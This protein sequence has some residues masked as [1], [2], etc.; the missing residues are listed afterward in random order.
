MI[1]K[2]LMCGAIFAKGEDHFLIGYGKRIWS[3]HAVNSSSPSWYF[4][5]FFLESQMPWFT[6]E[7][8]S[9]ISRIELISLLGSKFMEL[10]PLIWEKLCEDVFERSFCDLQQKFAEKTL[11]KVVPYLV[12]RSSCRNSN[13]RLL[14]ML[15]A[16]LKHVEKGRMAIYGFWDM[17]EGILGATPELLFEQDGEVSV[18][19]MACA[20][21]L[22]ANAKPTQILE[23]KLLKEHQIVVDDMVSSLTVL[24]KVS[25]GKT[26]WQSFRTL[27]HLITPMLLQAKKT[28]NFEQLI[29]ALHP[30]A[31]LGAYPKAEGMKWLKNYASQIPRKRYGAPV[32]YQLNGT[33]VCHV[34]IRNVQWDENGFLIAAG[35]GIIPESNLE[36]EK[37]E[38]SVKISAIKGSLNL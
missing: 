23:H 16:L 36:E 7:Y 18:R 22:P 8:W 9:C 5:D 31:A 29:A 24:G 15:N 12:E 3:Q 34:G 25:V 4:P 17:H 6:H 28:I 10:E 2:F 38:I 19:S 27:Q 37:R 20:A 21:T 32:G 33:A 11:L 1:D 14:Q 13:E 26:G 30:T 35:S